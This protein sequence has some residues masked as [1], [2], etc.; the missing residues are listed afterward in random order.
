M[1]AKAD[2]RRVQ[3]WMGHADVATTM[4]YLHYVERPDE[5]RLVAEAFAV[6]EVEPEN[7]KDRLGG[8]S[9]S[10]IGRPDS[11]L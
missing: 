6:D 9:T 4:K 7:D 8:R 10:V 5:A 2:I 1:I 3:E 11:D